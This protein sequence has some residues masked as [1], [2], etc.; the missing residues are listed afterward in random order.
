M[1]SLSGW[2]VL[3]LLV[4]GG[5]VRQAPMRAVRYTLIVASTE[6]EFSSGCCRVLHPDLSDARRI[7]LRRPLTA[8]AFLSVVVRDRHADVSACCSPEERCETGGCGIR[9][10]IAYLRPRSASGLSSLSAV[11]ERNTGCFAAVGARKLRDADEKNGVDFWLTA[12][13]Y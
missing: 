11:A 3:G 6:H 7:G 13:Y 10:E 8:A 5:V 2:L 12:W 9:S 4:A 1:L